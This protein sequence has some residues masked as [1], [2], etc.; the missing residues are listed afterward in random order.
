MEH[1][2]VMEDYANSQLEKV[3]DFLKSEQRSP[4]YIDLILEPSKIHAHHWVE[5]RVKTPEYSV[6]SNY[7]GSKLYDVL[8][9]VIDIMYSELHEKK[10][11]RKKDDKKTVG[12]HE[13]FKK[14]R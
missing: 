9:R 7:E 5:L 3:I 10:A 1:S 12:R 8:D 11:R 6:I 4:I 13:E 14:Q 2:D